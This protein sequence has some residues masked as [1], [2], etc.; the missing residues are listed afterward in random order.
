MSR[1]FLLA[2]GYLASVALIS[3]GVGLEYGS[4]DAF[5]TAGILV[6]IPVILL[7]IID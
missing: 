5:V 4:G 6:M 2:L 1:R 3:V 7:R